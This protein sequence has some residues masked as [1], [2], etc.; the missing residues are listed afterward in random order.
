MGC[1]KG[2]SKEPPASG[3]YQCSKCGAVAAKKEHLCKPK[4]VKGASGSR[5]KS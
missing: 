4:K 2:K 1:Q 5:G 3:G